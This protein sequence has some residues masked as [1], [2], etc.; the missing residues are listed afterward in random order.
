MMA[1]G[2]RRKAEGNRS[3]VT[4]H[5]SRWAALVLSAALLAGCDY[6]VYTSVKD[7]LAAPGKF[8]G[9][10]V[11]LKGTVTDAKHL[12]LINVQTYTLQ[13]GDAKIA[14]IV[15]QGTLPAVNDRVKLKGTVKSA[16]IV[17]GK[18]VGQRVEETQRLK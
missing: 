10:E 6:F 5:G 15:L 16:M 13:D 14:V 7:V 4:G 8:E 9:V 2:G 3:P 1:N 12:P 17:N 11:K 18:A